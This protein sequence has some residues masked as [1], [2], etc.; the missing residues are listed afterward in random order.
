MATLTRPQADQDALYKLRLGGFKDTLALMLVV[1]AGLFTSPYLAGLYF[2]PWDFP[3]LGE[4]GALGPFYLAPWLPMMLAACGGAWFAHRVLG[5][6]YSA[7]HVLE[8]ELD[9]VSSPSPARMDAHGDLYV[10]DRTGNRRPTKGLLFGYTTDRAEP[11]FIDDES[12]MQHVFIIGQSGVGKTVAASL[13]MFQQIQRGGGVLFVDGKLDAKN[14]EALYHYCCWCGRSQDFLVINPGDPANS[15]TY[16]PIAKGDPDEIASRILLLIPS[17][18]NSPGADHYKQ[19]ANQGIIT[20]VSALQAANWA[21]TMMDLSVLL[22]NGKALQDLER[23]LINMAPRSVATK[24][25]RLFLDKFRIPANDKNG[26]GGEID[27]QKLKNTFGGVG[28]RLF[29]F[30]SGK[31]GEVMNTYAPDVDL[32]DAVR[33]NKV[34]YCALPTMGKSEAAQ[35]FGKILVGDF[36]T[37]VSWIQALPEEQRPSPPF[38]AFFDEAGAYV[39]ESWP[40]IFEQARSAKIMLMPAVQTF[41]NFKAVSEE[42]AEM[43]TGNTWI[44]LFFKIGTHVSALEA[45]ELI[46]MEMSKINTITESASDSKSVQFLKADPDHSA[47]GGM[48]LGQ[49]EREQEDYRVSADDLK[50]L[51]RGQCVMTYGGRDLFDL[52]IPLLKIDAETA[53]HFGTT[54]INRYRREYVRG[55]NLFSDESLNRLLKIDKPEKPEG[56]KKGGAKR[57]A[58]G[59]DDDDDGIAGRDL[60]E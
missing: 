24:N 32:Y 22:G 47:S 14:I 35:N 17:T 11:V 45:A 28:G 38:M 3:S 5:E 2:G 60:D 9:I 50:A 59:D 55:A 30:G 43:V 52:R 25:F 19:E 58:G 48:G 10:T 33:K 26:Q 20:L 39:G 29:A 21:Y 23:R 13:L 7:Q 41:A 15:N 51:D 53:K 40:R 36:R 37:A 56:G 42:L 4:G 8:T 31:F 34:I 6:A 54:R 27:I 49:G 12:L 57:R 46:G 1:F 44:K 18:S 16:N